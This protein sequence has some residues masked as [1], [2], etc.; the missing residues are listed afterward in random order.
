MWALGCIIYQMLTGISPFYADTEYLIYENINGYIDH[1]RPINFPSSVQGISKQLVEAL[2]KKC[3]SER[4]TAWSQELTVAR[5]IKNHEFFKNMPWTKI[6]TMKPPYIPNPSDL[7]DTS[8]MKDGE[9]DEWIFEGDATMIYDNLELTQQDSLSKSNKQSKWSKF[10]VSNETVIFASLTWKRKG[11]FSK[12]RQLILTSTPRLIY[13]DPDPGKMELKGEIPWKADK[14]LKCVPV[15]YKICVYNI[16]CVECIILYNLVYKERM[17]SNSYILFYIY[18]CI[19]I[20]LF[21]FYYYLYILLSL[22]IVKRR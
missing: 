20:L 21:I 8:N 6:P 10:L 7:P 1:K 12:K 9:F 22:S 2:L 19:I 4:L 15:S 5:S 18:Y 13:V 11:L 3:P 14:P 16:I 17:I